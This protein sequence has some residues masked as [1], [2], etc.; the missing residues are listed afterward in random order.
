[1]MVRTMVPVFMLLALGCATTIQLTTNG[2]MVRNVSAGEMPTGC[3]L[4]GDVPIGI[5]P[6]A[7]RP[8]TEEQLVILMRNRTAEMGGNRVVVDSAH[9]DG[10]GPESYWRG[11][12]VAY[13]CSDEDLR[14][15]AAPPEE[16][17]I[18]DEAPAAEESAAEPAEEEVEEEAPPRRRRGG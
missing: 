8:R 10:S 6:D 16:P 14:E 5:P 18:D 17:A 11:R 15:P 2:N 12:G 1:M 7:A 3:N 9:Q 13:A 4:L